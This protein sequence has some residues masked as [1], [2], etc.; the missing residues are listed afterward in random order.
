MCIRDRSQAVDKAV[1]QTL[2]W[3]L[4]DNSLRAVPKA[5]RDTP[6]S[7]T[8]LMA[9]LSQLIDFDTAAIIAEEMGCK[10]E[11]EVVVTIEEKLIDDHKD[12]SLIHI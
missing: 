7:Y 9:S 10:V 1:G 11:K 12:L 5:Q 3:A 2:L 6:V 8:H 4:S